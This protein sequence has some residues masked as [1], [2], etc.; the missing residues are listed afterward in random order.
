MCVPLQTM[1]VVMPWMMIVII[2]MAVVVMLIAHLNPPLIEQ[3]RA[4][5]GVHP[6]TGQRKRAS[7]SDRVAPGA[8]PASP[9]RGIVTGKPECDDVC[10]A[11]CGA[12]EV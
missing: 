7:D 2:G 1:I 12:Q 9:R 6:K 5:V 11:E 3:H 8:P 4:S 10:A